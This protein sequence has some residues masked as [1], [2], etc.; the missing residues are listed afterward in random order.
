[1]LPL[2][3]AVEP[4]AGGT[5][6]TLYVEAQDI[7]HR[8]VDDGRTADLERLGG[9]HALRRREVAEHLVLDGA[10]HAVVREAGAV[11]QDHGG[12][13][14]IQGPCRSDERL[15][16]VA[17]RHLDGARRLD[18][19]GFAHID[20]EVVSAGH[21]EQVLARPV[22]DLLAL[23][24]GRDARLRGADVVVAAVR[25]DLHIGAAAG[26]H[27]VVPLVVVEDGVCLTFLAPK[28]ELQR[29]GSGGE[30]PTARRGVKGDGVFP[31]ADAG[32]GDAVH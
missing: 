28:G 23:R 6:A 4:V 19:G 9:I 17:H 22:H 15:I 3:L 27:V 12:D 18:R 7:R 20:G 2:V 31:R 8:V 16:G 11:R 32:G 24:V 13:G 29:Y 26:H 10:E 21:G 25:R 5:A 30:K 1:M 14:D